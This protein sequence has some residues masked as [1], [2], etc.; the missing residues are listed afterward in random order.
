MDIIKCLFF[1]WGKPRVCW[2]D[3]KTGRFVKAPQKFRLTVGLNG[4]VKHHRYKNFTETRFV[5]EHEIEDAENE[6]R[7]LLIEKG[8]KFLGF[9]LEEWW[10]GEFGEEILP[11]GE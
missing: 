8:E 5:Y 6:M 11:V 10:C 7:E 9:P 2:R 4:L 3:K 1:L